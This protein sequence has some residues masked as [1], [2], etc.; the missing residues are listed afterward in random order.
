[1]FADQGDMPTY[2]IRWPHNEK[3]HTNILSVEADNQYDLKLT[4]SPM[5]R[6]HDA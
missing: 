3:Q 4:T 1:M 6:K 2:R 5:W